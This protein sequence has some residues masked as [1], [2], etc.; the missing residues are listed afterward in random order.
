MPLFRGHALRSIAIAGLVVLGAH[1]LIRHLPD[2]LHALTVTQTSVAIVALSSLMLVTVAHHQRGGRVMTQTQEEMVLIGAFGLFWLSVLVALRAF[3]T[4]G[5]VVGAS[6]LG[7]AGSWAGLGLDDRMRMPR[8]HQDY[9]SW[10]TAGAYR[11]AG[12]ALGRPYD[13]W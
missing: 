10:G 8:L 2:T 7:A 13:A 1:Q 3:G 11:R 9:S 5:D 6:G 12:R 4:R